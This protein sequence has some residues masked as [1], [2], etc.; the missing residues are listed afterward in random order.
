[1]CLI[2]RTPVPVGYLWTVVPVS[3]ESWSN[4]YPGFLRQCGRGTASLSEAEAEAEAERP[5]ST[6]APAALKARHFHGPRKFP[7]A[8][9]GPGRARGPGPGLGLRVRR[10]QWPVGKSACADLRSSKA[11]GWGSV[12][13]LG[14]HAGHAR[15]GQRERAVA[16]RRGPGRM[17][18]VQVATPSRNS[19]G[20]AHWRRVLRV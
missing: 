17:R 16:V 8:P 10:K 2:D 3:E 18:P 1:M 7:R 14:G 15:A 4:N 12:A 13:G 20:R 6:S 5:S 11:N 9:R 19:A